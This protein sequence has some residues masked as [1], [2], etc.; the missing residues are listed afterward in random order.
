MFECST[1]DH[2]TDPDHALSFLGICLAHEAGRGLVLHYL[3]AASCNN[4]KAWQ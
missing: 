2:H 3:S 1:Y 4:G